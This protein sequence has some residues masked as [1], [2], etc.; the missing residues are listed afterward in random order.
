MTFTL[1]NVNDCVINTSKLV[2]R[3]N[4]DNEREERKL[5]SLDENTLKRVNGT[6]RVVRRQLRCSGMDERSLCFMAE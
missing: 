6:P 2:G 5:C 4:A 3:D 1:M